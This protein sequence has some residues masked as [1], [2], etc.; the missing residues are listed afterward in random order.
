M[1][2]CSHWSKSYSTHGGKCSLKLYG[3]EPSLITC[4]RCGKN[5]GS[6]GWAIALFEKFLGRKLEPPKPVDESDWPLPIR[7]LARKRKL[8]QRGVGDTLAAMFGGT[9]D[10]LKRA[11]KIMNVDCGCKRRQEFLNVRYPYT[12]PAAP[13][14]RA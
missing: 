7:L 14:P 6:P 10:K 5:D 9:G 11:M 2:T 3:G 13:P 12:T 4:S 8:G 1:K